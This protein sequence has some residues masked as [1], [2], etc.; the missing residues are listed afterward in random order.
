[1]HADLAALRKETGVAAFLGVQICRGWLREWAPTA[2]LP[3][4]VAKS[5]RPAAPC[6]R[7]GAADK[8]DGRPVAAHSGDCRATTVQVTP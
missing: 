2:S 5:D 4:T 6:S 3:A 1:M 8:V 7:K